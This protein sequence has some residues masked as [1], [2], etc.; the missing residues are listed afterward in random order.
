MFLLGHYQILWG[1]IPHSDIRNHKACGE[2]NALLFRWGC[3]SVRRLDMY[4][5]SR[6]EPTQVAGKEGVKRKPLC[7]CVAIKS[8]LLWGVQTDIAGWKRMGAFLSKSNYSASLILISCEHYL[9][10]SEPMRKLAQD[11]RL[12]FKRREFLQIRFE[13]L[14]GGTQEVQWLSINAIVMNE[15]SFWLV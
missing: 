3:E 5:L 4:P 6:D 12:P 14:P 1:L 7:G 8:S 15:Q 13:F 9:Y 10:P 2:G 11:N